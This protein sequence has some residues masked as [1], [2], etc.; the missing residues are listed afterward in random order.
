MRNVF[1]KLFWTLDYTNPPWIQSER[2]GLHIFR[3]PSVTSSISCVCTVCKFLIFIHR[4]TREPFQKDLWVLKLTTGKQI[5]HHQRTAG[6]E[7]T[8]LPVTWCKSCLR[9]ERADPCRHLKELSL[10][11]T[12][13]K[14]V[15]FILSQGRRIQGLSCGMLPRSS[16]GE[17]QLELTIISL[18]RPHCCCLNP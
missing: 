7:L 13:L 9:S 1:K 15:V 18:K 5:V 16:R 2:L 17:F 12:S 4:C 8:R 6:R 3:L 11:F 10:G 14:C